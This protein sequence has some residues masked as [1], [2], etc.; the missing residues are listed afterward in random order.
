L[1]Q[2]GSR[3]FVASRSTASTDDASKESSQAHANHTIDMSG[4]V[5]PLK[6][7]RRRTCAQSTSIAAMVWLA[8]LCVLI[9][10]PILPGARSTRSSPDPASSG[11]L[12]ML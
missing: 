6:N 1:W 12:A 2:S 4:A 11:I 10:N 9:L 5:R 8:R 7:Q 3:E